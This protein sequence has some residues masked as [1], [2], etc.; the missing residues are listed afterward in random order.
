MVRTG[1]EHKRGGGEPGWRWGRE[2]EKAGL[3]MAR[4]RSLFEN[5]Y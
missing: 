3:D 1:S 4:G 2:G 5:N